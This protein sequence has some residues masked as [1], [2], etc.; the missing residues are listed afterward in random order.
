VSILQ[1]KDSSLDVKE[2][3]IKMLCLYARLNFWT[4]I[5]VAPGNHSVSLTMWM[6]SCNYGWL[7]ILTNWKRPGVQ[8]RCC[9]N[10]LF[11]QS[12]VQEQGLTFKK[13]K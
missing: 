5:D 8:M 2:K 12:I 1:E 11:W 13:G 10:A 9:G 7:E 3:N 6:Q 4:C